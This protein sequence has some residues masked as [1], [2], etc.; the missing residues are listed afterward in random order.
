M[1]TVSKALNVLEKYCKYEAISYVETSGDLKLINVAIDVV[2]ETEENVLCRLF[3]NAKDYKIF[4]GQLDVAKKSETWDEPYVSI[5]THNDGT[6][7]L[8]IETIYGNT[9]I[10]GGLNTKLLHSIISELYPETEGSV[11]WNI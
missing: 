5:F 4:A 3:V 1:L 9:V 2:Q 11:V 8:V 6:C 10:F 7:E